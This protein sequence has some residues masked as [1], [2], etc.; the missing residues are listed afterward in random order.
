MRVGHRQL[1]IPE[2]P[3]RFC[4]GGFSLL[5][6][7][8]YIILLIFLSEWKYPL[9]WSCV[10]YLYCWLILT[11]LDLQDILMITSDRRYIT[12]SHGILRCV[13]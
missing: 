11:V 3:L 8:Y 6:K 1:S 13:R 2:N 7:N 9:K 4:E 5:L 12:I 10:L